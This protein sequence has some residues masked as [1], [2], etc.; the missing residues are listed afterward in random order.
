MAQGAGHAGMRLIL[1]ACILGFVPLVAHADELRFEIPTLGGFE[2]YV[3]LLEHPGYIGVVLENNDLPPTTS[4]K[5]IL[6]DRG[7]EVQAKSGI[8]RFIGRS[9]ALYK[10]EGGVSLGIGKASITVPAYADVSQ[11]A[12]GKVV[13]VA[14]L[15]LANLLSDDK[16]ARIDAKVRTLANMAV[17]QKI[18]DYL[19]EMA[20]SAGPEP[21]ALFET[22]L[23]DSYNRSGGPAAV[24][25][26]VG[27]A[28]PVSEQMMLIVT[29]AIWLILVP[30]GL[31]I[32]KLR[33]WRRATRAR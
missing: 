10:Y 12:S 26:D 33:R 18:L 30:A 23:L 32:Y 7:R 22:I 20:K 8:I 17:Q 15:P 21:G 24:H 4:S 6:R 5:I 25:A 16:R 3:A 11:I 14:N 31:L 29:L 19:D 1:W 27:D 9:G 13:L 28:V 2:R